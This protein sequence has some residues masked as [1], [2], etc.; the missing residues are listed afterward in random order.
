MEE[1]FGEGMGDMDLSENVVVEDA[2]EIFPPQPKKDPSFDV[3]GDFGNDGSS[4]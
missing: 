3:P 1:V 2:G 4:L